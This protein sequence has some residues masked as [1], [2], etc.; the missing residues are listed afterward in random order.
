MRNTIGSTV[1][2]R[3]NGVIRHCECGAYLPYGYMKHTCMK[4]L[5]KRDEKYCACG[6]P[7][8]GQSKYCVDCKAEK[9]R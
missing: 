7:I 2:T 6:N 5:A 8:I 4:C 9:I 3:A 1:Y